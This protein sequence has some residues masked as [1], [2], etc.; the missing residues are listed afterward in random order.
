MLVRIVLVWIEWEDIVKSKPKLPVFPI[1]K[2]SLIYGHPGFLVGDGQTLCQHS[3]DTNKPPIKRENSFTC[4]YSGRSIL[5]SR[6]HARFRCTSPKLLKS[7]RAMDL[8]NAVIAITRGETGRCNCLTDVSPNLV[9]EWFHF[10]LL[11]SLWMVS[12]AACALWRGYE[13]R[14]VWKTIISLDTH[15][16]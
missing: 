13:L 4:I 5:L 2:R 8:K 7:W 12:G 3:V 9:K 10:A 15:F 1:V 11:L 16:S 6:W 14:P